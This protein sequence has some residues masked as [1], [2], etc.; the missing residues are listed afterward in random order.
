[1][2]E[3]IGKWAFL[4]GLVIAVVVGFVEVPYS[5]VILLVLGL[6]VGFLNIAAKETTQYLVAAIALM[7]GA[8]AFSVTAVPGVVGDVVASILSAFV[9]FVAASALVVAVKAVIELSSKK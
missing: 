9:A 2:D 5:A 1:M 3:V 4:I 6:I 7:T 8:V